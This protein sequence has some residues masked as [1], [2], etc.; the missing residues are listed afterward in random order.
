MAEGMLRTMGR[1]QIAVFSAGIAPT[2]VHP[3][4]VHVMQR[5][6]FDIRDHTVKH[7][8]ILRGRRFVYA[9]TLSDSVRDLCPA[10]IDVISRLR[11]RIPDPVEWCGTTESDTETAF[12][13]TSRVLADH[14]HEFLRQIERDIGKLL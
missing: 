8:S 9:I 13:R 12:V 14:M 2:S 3:M 6:G 5:S 1:D 4:A 7:V 11:W 10:D